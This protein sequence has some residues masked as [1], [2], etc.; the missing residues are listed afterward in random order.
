MKASN[1][2]KQ[3]YWVF[4]ALTLSFFLVPSRNLLA[5]E[6]EAPS[7]VG[8]RKAITALSEK[9]GFQLSEKAQRRLNLRF[10]T[11]AQSAPY[12]VP[13][14]A[15]VYSQFEL[16]VYR[17]RQGWF[18]FVHVEKTSSPQPSDVS[19]SILSSELQ[20]GDQIVIQGT[21]LVRAADLEA[22]GGH[23]GGHDH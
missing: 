22:F 19:L 17:L 3:S 16:G 1:L 11:L 23:E 14:Q 8:P 2:I 5:D 4:L 10:L 6:D 21:G 20:A 18:K 7:S 9:E 15:L 12:R 13:A